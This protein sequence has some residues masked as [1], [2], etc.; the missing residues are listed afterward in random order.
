MRRGREGSRH[1]GAITVSSCKVAVPEEHNSCTLKQ[2]VLLAAVQCVKKINHPYCHAAKYTNRET[3]RANTT[4]APFRAIFEQR[5]QERKVRHPFWFPQKV[6]LKT[7]LALTIG[8][9]VL[10]ITEKKTTMVFSC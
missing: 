3:V 8:C 7:C 4:A 10:N 2:A 1:I 9:Y 6:L 5:I